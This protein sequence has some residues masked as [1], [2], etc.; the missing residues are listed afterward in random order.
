MH[1]SLGELRLLINEVMLAELD[2]EDVKG[3][4]CV[5]GSTHVMQTCKVGKDK[6]FL[7][8]SDASLFDEGD[9]SLQVLV[10]YLAYRIYQLYPGVNTPKVDLVYD[11]K[12]GKV[13]LASAAVSGKPGLSSFSPQKLGKMLS[14]GA[15]VD[16]FLANWDVVGTGQGNILVDKDKATRI[17]PG[18]ALT[19]RAQ[20]GRKGSKFSDTPGELKTM[21]DPGFGAGEVLSHADLKKASASFLAVPWSA[22][23][24]TIKDVGHQ[25]TKDLLERGMGDLAKQW[26][27]DV[28]EISGKLAKR[29]KAISAQVV[30]ATR[31]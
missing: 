29:H 11:R 15:Y 13:G 31:L 2:I 25:V 20:G 10:E 22:V 17:D 3:A 4:T 6:Y 1:V 30:A 14:A 5:A 12:N 24:A 27:A 26:Q 23:A 9:P 21:M 18:G 19:F 28:A 7:K 16:V 8:F